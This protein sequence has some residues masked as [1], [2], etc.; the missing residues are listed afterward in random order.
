MLHVSSD[1]CDKRNGLIQWRGVTGV[2]RFGLEIQRAVQLI[3]V[4]N[5]LHSLLQMRSNKVDIGRKLR[6][7]G[8]VVG[9]IG[10]GA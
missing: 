2:V 5:V 8:R 10:M 7:L 4:G 1:T 6:G 9:A 3:G